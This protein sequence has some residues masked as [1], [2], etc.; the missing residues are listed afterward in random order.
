MKRVRKSNKLWTGKAPAL[1]FFAFFWFVLGFEASFLLDLSKPQAW[2]GYDPGGACSHEEAEAEETLVAGLA[3]QAHPHESLLMR[4][5]DG[6]QV[7]Y[8]PKS[9][10]PFEGLSASFH[11]NSKVRNLFRYREGRLLSARGWNARGQPSATHV[12][13]GSGF[14]ME[15]EDEE[16]GYLYED[17]YEIAFQGRI[18]SGKLYRKAFA[19]GTQTIYSVSG[20]PLRK[21]RTKKG[22]IDGLHQAWNGR[23]QLVM[24]FREQPGDQDATIREWHDNGR[25][26][27]IMRTRNGNP[28]GAYVLYCEN[29]K[30]LLEGSYAKGR[31]T[32]YWKSYYPT[33]GLR[34]SGSYL[35]GKKTGWHTFN[36]EDGKIL[37]L[38]YHKG[39]PVF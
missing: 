11:D 23:G 28:H 38:Y 36:R 5:E 24:E 6:R 20:N 33:G 26:K 27:K 7:A 15:L 21:T 29:G 2:E 19:D 13:E 30:P 4:G 32:G 12:D 37:R 35:N 16:V 31:R 34:Y 1:L 25:I 9:S 8:L 18:D 17:G 10:V 3:S 14:V 22:K 39:Y